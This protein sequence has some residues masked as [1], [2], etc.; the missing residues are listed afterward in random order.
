[1]NRTEEGVR[2]IDPV[3]V[4]DSDT[5]S[6]AAQYDH[7]QVGLERIE[8]QEKYLN[9]GY[10]SGRERSYEEKQ[11]E[12]C[13]QVFALAEIG[14]GDTVVD[15]GFGSG[16]QDFLLARERSFA[17]LHGFNI[18][19]RQVDYARARAR[20]AGL[21]ERLRFHHGAAEDLSV[22][23]DASVDAVVA[24]EC[25]FYFDRPRFYAEAARVLRPGGRLALADIT[26]HERLRAIGGWESFRRVGTF[27]RNRAAWERH[28]TTRSV[29]SIRR[30]AR[31]GAQQAAWRCFS[32]ITYGLTWPE[33]KTWLSMGL[34]TE[35][36]V[37]GLLAGFIRY[38]L[39]LLEKPGGAAAPRG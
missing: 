8:K 29:R 23:T 30:E 34:N 21:A 18:A 33:L 5:A 24:I 37:L 11:A 7:F 25:A 32:S 31:S 15:V 39:I 19:A 3:P 27:D 9:Y 14:A 1:M 38:D 10:D 17:V 35:I 26:F 28:F 12:L 2:G 22:L 20:A 16:E 4:F 36:V 13:R 6:V